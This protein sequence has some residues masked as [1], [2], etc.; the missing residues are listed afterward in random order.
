MR[1]RP[2][3]VHIEHRGRVRISPHARRIAGDADQIANARGVRSQQLALD[4][5]NVPVAAAEMQH[6]L[7]PGVLLNQLAGHLR[8]QP[9]AGARAV[10]HIDAVDPS[11]LAELRSGDFLGGIDAL[12]RKNLDEA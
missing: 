3:R 10:R 9:R 12:G 6:R 11:V 7:D 5:Q 4:A 8:A 1:I 2:D